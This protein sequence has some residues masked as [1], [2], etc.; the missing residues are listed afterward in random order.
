MKEAYKSIKGYEGLYEVSNLGNVK[1]LERQGKHSKGGKMIIKEKILT[2]SNNGNGYFKVHLTI[3][4]KT[5]KIYIHQL[6]AMAFLNHTPNGVKNI[7]DHIDNNSKNNNLNNLQLI[8]QRE[9][10]SKDKINKTSK[11]TGVH[12]LKKRN[13]WQASIRI[14]GSKVYLGSF[15]DESLAHDAYQKELKKLIL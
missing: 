6:V 3:N 4:N 2:N 10:S 15:S 8:T 14:N 12:W 9:N 5:K 7:V 1:S 11:Y 13:K